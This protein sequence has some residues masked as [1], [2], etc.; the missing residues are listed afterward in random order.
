MQ[1]NTGL[2]VLEQARQ[3]VA[4]AQAERW[5]QTTREDDVPS[6]LPLTSMG[7][8]RRG[9]TLKHQGSDQSDQGD[10]SSAASR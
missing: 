2:Q 5:Q 3:R 6:E 10:I 9:S 1:V 4:D 7:L 8:R